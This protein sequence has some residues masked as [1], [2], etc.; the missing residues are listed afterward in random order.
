[1]AEN[2]LPSMRIHKTGKEIHHY[3]LVIRYIVLKAWDIIEESKFSTAHKGE[4]SEANRLMEYYRDYCRKYGLPENNLSIVEPGDPEYEPILAIYFS[5]IDKNKLES[6][7]NYHKKLYAEEDFEDLIEFRVYGLIDFYVPVDN[8][9]RKRI[10]MKWIIEQRTKERPPKDIVENFTVEKVER[11]PDIKPL[12]WKANKEILKRLSKK[13]KQDKCIKSVDDFKKVFKN[14][15]TV[16]YGSAE[17]LAYLIY[18]ITIKPYDWIESENKPP[19]TKSV[20]HYFTFCDYSG[21][22]HQRKDLS[23]VLNNV[24]QRSAEKHKGLRTGIDS[25]LSNILK[26]A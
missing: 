26:S 23:K 17:Y 3:D 5:V 9:E 19:Y 24:I 1:M 8:D 12:R 7:L 15:V 21:K 11:K 2:V 6:A 18:K 25:M 20:Q 22:I 16:W 14:N 4:E 13:L 10:I